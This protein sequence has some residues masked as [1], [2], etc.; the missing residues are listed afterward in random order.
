V[1]LAQGTYEAAF[2]ALA[3]AERLHRGSEPDIELAVRLARGEWELCSG[4]YEAAQAV[5]RSIVD[6]A[7]QEGLPSWGTRGYLQLAQAHRALAGQ[8]DTASR[9]LHKCLEMAEKTGALPEQIRSRTL[10]AEIDAAAGSLEQSAEHLRKVEKLVLECSSRPLFLPFS[11]ALGAFYRRRGDLE[12]ALSV[13]DT[14][15]KLASYLTMPDWTWRFLAA[16]GHV[17]V[18]LKRHDHAASYYRG[19]VEILAALVERL[20]AG[21]REECLQ[22]RDKAALESGLRTCHETLVGQKNRPPERVASRQD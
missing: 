9:Y 13:Y 15:R 11:S 8:A 5:G 2:S 19:G 21:H 18:D 3:E 20:P 4:R 16:S 14:A 22:E 1:A 17:L 12:M 7:Q 10:L 6:L